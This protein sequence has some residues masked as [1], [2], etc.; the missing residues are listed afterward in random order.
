MPQVETEAPLR[1][2]DTQPFSKPRRIVSICLPGDQLLLQLAPRECIAALSN[3]ATDSD[4]SAHWED[5][6]G[7]PTT[8]GSAEELVRLRPD[9][10]ICSRYS[11]PLTISILKRLGL[12]VLSLDIP[13][14]FDD[15]RSQIRRVGQALGEEARAEQVVAEVDARLKRLAAQCPPPGSRPTALFYFQDHYTPGA[16][17]FPNAIL[18][19]AGFRNIAS[20][21]APGT[22]AWASEEAIVMA[23]PQFLI[24]T[25]YR[26]AA[27]TATQ[28]SAE[29][30]IFRKLG[31]DVQLIS[32][33]FRDLVSPDPSNLGFSEMLQKHIHQ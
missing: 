31:S 17:T 33:S 9:L 18:E 29:Q 4:I 20:T 23:R 30:P 19:V 11:S 27:P 24:L 2:A 10:V 13:R 1:Q 32:V 5:A 7:L 16:Q 26:D 12:R 21:F 3:L 28:V 14:D 15:M 8:R 22:D 6:R 25:R